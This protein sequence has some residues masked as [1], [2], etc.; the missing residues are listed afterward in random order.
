[1]W[2][3]SRDDRRLYQVLGIDRL[4]VSHEEARVLWHG[5]QDHEGFHQTMFFIE[6]ESITIVSSGVV[7]FHNANNKRFSPMLELVKDIDVNV[8]EVVTDNG[9]D[10]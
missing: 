3:R 5:G 10:S 1:M 4:K 7:H 9:Y 8:S 2:V 6:T